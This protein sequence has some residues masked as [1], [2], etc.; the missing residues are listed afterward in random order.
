[1]TNY[2]EIKT[3]FVKERLK[4]LDFNQENEQ[5]IQNLMRIENYATN[6]LKGIGFAGGQLKYSLM[7]IYSKEWLKIFQELNPEMYIHYNEFFSREK[8][9]LINVNMDQKARDVKEKKQSKKS[10]E[11]VRNI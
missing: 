11:E 7:Q 3:K 9:E 6:D 1:M 2:T 4:E 5:Y 10:W 8:K